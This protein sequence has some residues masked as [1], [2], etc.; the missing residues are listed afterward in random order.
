MK[1]LMWV[2]VDPELVGTAEDHPDD[3]VA[4]AGARRLEGS[5]LR[6]VAD[7]TTLWPRDGGTFVSDG[8]FAETKEQ[9]AGYDILDCADLAE[10]ID[11]AAAHPVAKFGAIELRPVWE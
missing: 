5:Q 1:F 7:A 10:A 6:S 11:I 9:I 2:C 4:E 3:W 8:P